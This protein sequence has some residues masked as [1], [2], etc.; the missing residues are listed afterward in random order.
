[1]R[2]SSTPS[3]LPPTAILQDL[4]RIVQDKCRFYKNIARKAS[5]VCGMSVQKSS[6]TF[7]VGFLAF[8]MTRVCALLSFRC[9]KQ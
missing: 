8:F 9:E 1:M 4:A 7:S 5:H 6:L 3:L 2:C